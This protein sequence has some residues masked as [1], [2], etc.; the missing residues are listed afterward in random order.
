MKKF[1]LIK[2]AIIVCMSYMGKCMW[3]KSISLFTVWRILREGHLYGRVAVEKPI[4]N[5][6]HVRKRLSWCKSYIGMLQ[7][8][9]EN[10]LLS[11]ETR[12][13]L[14]LLVADVRRTVVSQFKNRYVVKTVNKEVFQ[15]W[16]GMYKIWWNKNLDSFSTTSGFHF[17]SMCFETW[18]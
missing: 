14:F 12:M 2:S 1:I 18:H 6:T 17:T 7:S 10:V 11:D 5:K 15:F 3:S 9:M 13:E 4:L 16:C 8:L